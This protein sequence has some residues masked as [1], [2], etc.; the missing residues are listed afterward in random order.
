[1]SRNAWH[2][3][4]AVA[5]PVLLVLACACRKGDDDRSIVTSCDADPRDHTIEV[6]EQVSCKDPHVS[7][8]GR[9]LITWRSKGGENIEVRFTPREGIDPFPDL[10]CPGNSPVCQSGRI[11][12]NASGRYHYDVW[13]MTANGRKEIDP[14]VI[15]DP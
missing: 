11:A 3:F 5:L 4:A 12:P 2:V 8:N 14:M 15:I 9:H 1:M 7:K 10:R 13:L 6:G